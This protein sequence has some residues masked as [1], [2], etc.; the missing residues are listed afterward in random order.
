MVT[1]HREYDREE[2]CCCHFMGYPFQLAARDLLYV[3]SHKQD[4]TYHGVCYTSCG[5]LAGMRIILMGPPG[6]VDS[7]TYHTMSV[8][9]TTD[10]S[11]ASV[12]AWP[13]VFIFLY[14][15]YNCM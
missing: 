15:M 6:G 4:S 10:L 1:D 11:P 8:R 3:L 12:L 5:A 2:T 9:S 14:F 13:S 7:M